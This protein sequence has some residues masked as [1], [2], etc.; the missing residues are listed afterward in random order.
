MRNVVIQ[1][2]L[3]IEAAMRN[4]Y[5]AARQLCFGYCFVTIMSP[6]KSSAKY[7]IKD[8]VRRCAENGVYPVYE[9]QNYVHF[10]SG[11]VLQTMITNREGDGKS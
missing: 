8:I 2:V 9:S 6:V 4:R 3:S 1:D 5:A 11:A 10:D 7:Y